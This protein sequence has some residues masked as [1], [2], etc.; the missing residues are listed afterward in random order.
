MVVKKFASDFAS[1][2]LDTV[3]AYGLAAIYLTKEYAER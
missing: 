1:I 2:L 3:F